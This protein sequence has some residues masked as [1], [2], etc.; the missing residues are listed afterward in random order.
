M[1]T[2]ARGPGWVI[3]AATS[4]FCKEL[5]CHYSSPNNWLLVSSGQPRVRPVCQSAPCVQV[6]LS[7]LWS[8]PLAAEGWGCKFRAAARQCKPSL[9][10]TAVFSAIKVSFALFCHLLALVDVAAR[11]APGA[12]FYLTEVAFKSSSP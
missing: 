11:G 3:L 9:W 4:H 8:E 1:S 5:R 12:H 2:K 7:I 10:T 6:V